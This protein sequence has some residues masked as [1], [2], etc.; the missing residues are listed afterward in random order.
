MFPNV[1]FGYEGEPSGL[2]WLG[3]VTHDGTIDSTYSFASQSFGLPHPSRVMTYAV[4]W[5]TAHFSRTLSSATID[6]VSATINKQ[7]GHTGGSTGL[8]VAIISALV[9]NGA[10]GTI[11]INFGGA[12][13]ECVISPFRSTGLVSITP[14]DT[15]SVNGVNDTD[16]NGNIDVSNNGTLLIAGTGSTNTTGHSIAFTGADELYDQDAVTNGRMG[17]ALS[18]NLSAQGSRSCRF[19]MGGIADSG[20]TMVAVSFH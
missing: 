6:G 13:N 19:N 8:G 16:I 4:H 5:I 2:E 12:C 18:N 3:T 11:V 7:V 9:P 17:A 20:T 15:L 10:S 1:L 14:F